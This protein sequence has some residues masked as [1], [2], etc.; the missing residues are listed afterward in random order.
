MSAEGISHLKYLL[1]PMLVFLLLI[2][3]SISSKN[4]LFTTLVCLLICIGLIGNLYLNQKFETDSNQKQTELIKFLND[5]SLHY[6]YSDYWD[7]NLITYL[8]KFLVT[9]RAITIDNNES[10]KT[11]PYNSNDNWYNYP[12][13]ADVFILTSNENTLLTDEKLSY[14]LSIDPPKKK[15]LC[16]EYSI[17]VW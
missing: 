16:N 6:G 4:K 10:V 8:S 2:S 13:G 14:V 7:S 9:V 5:N 15:L 17:Y 11:Y 3:L 12:D 1:Y